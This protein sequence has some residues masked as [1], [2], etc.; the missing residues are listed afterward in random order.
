MAEVFDDGVEPDSEGRVVSHLMIEG[1][2]TSIAL[3]R[4]EERLVEVKVGG[5][6]RRLGGGGPG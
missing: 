3:Q 2:G 4:E 1:D 6:L 5:S